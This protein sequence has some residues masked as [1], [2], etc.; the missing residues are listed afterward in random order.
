MSRITLE[1][2][3]ANTKSVWHCVLEIKPEC[4]ELRTDI[5]FWNME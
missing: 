3:D 1:V 4:Y 5:F 2:L